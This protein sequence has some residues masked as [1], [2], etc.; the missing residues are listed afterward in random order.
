M[1]YVRKLRPARAGVVLAVV[2]LIC[3]VL[4]GTATAGN[5]GTNTHFKLAYWESATGVYWT[6]SGVHKVSK[7]GGVSDS[8]TCTTTAS[9][10][11]GGPFIVGTYSSNALV[12]PSGFPGGCGG[13]EP[14]VPGYLAPDG[15]TY[16]VSD[17]PGYNACAQFVTNTF[18]PTTSGGWTDTINASY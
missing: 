13:Y 9:Q 11:L 12:F 17:A 3:A 6:C 15:Y 4:A 16:W 10:G 14:G 7:T 5:G 8:E 2:A 1:R 18:A